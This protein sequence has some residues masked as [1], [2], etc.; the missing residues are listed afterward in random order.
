[1]KKMGAGVATATSLASLAVLPKAMATGSTVVTHTENVYGKAAFGDCKR[2]YNGFTN[3]TDQE[4]AAKGDAAADLGTK[5]AAASLTLISSTPTTAPLKALEIDP[6][7]P[8]TSWGTPTSTLIK[9]ISGI[10][11]IFYSEYEAT[12]SA[13]RT[14]SF[15][16]VV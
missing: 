13:S 5:W 1:L 14:A 3:D 16:E 9:H 4:E 7:E 8:T 10:T 6:G 12:C 2:T 15:T 11:P